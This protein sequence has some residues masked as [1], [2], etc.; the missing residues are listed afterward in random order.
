MTVKERSDEQECEFRQPEEDFTG[1]VARKA[2]TVVVLVGVI[3]LY[4]MTTVHIAFTQ[5]SIQQC[6]P[7]WFC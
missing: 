7:L 2:Y 3:M 1:Q 4:L 6:L 5:W